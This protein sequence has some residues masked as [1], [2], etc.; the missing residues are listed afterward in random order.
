MVE[1]SDSVCLMRETL[2]REAGHREP[3]YGV[4]V[5]VDSDGPG[6]RYLKAAPNIS[7]I[8]LGREGKM[9]LHLF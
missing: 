2:K 1:N 4:V 8:D 7:W 3:S 9:S 5:V 6:W